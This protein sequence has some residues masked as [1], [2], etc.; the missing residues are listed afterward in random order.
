[1]VETFFISDTHWFH[2]KIIGFC[3]RPF[4]SIEEMNETMVERWNSVVKPSDEVYHLGD[5]SFGTREQTFNL[6]SRLNGNKGLVRGNHDI[7]RI[8]LGSGTLN[9]VAWVKDYHELSQKRYGQKIVLL[10]YP[11]QAW[12]KS[13]FGSYHLHG[14]E[15]GGGSNRV[16]GRLL[17]RLDVAVESHNYTPINFEEVK[18]Y[19]EAIE[20][21]MPEER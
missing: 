17:R 9:G 20:V 5:L 1:M 7:K 4:E 3:G 6:M 14:H 18:K 10:H 13:H 2:K 16:N 21:V 11:M 19:M 8:K 15:H 12:N